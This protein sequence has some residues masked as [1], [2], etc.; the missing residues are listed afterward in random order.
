MLGV[1]RAWRWAA[2]TGD[3]V[4]AQSQGVRPLLQEPT[5]TRPLGQAEGAHTSAR[6]SL[7]ILLLSLGCD[8]PQRCGPPKRAQER[9]IWGLQ[10]KR[11][12]KAVHLRRCL[13]QGLHSWGGV[14]LPDPG[15]PSGADMSTPPG[16][17]PDSRVPRPPGRRRSQPRLALEQRWA[18]QCPRRPASS[19]LLGDVKHHDH[20]VAVLVHIQELRV[21]GHLGLRLQTGNQT[22]ETGH[23][24][25]ATSWRGLNVSFKLKRHPLFL[26]SGEKKST[27]G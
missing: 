22:S 18:S 15:L 8:E 1:G 2:P 7:L 11:Q 12:L 16:P 3:A 23:D 27:Q 21:Q 17:L 13:Q 6:P 25:R 24:P 9:G 19:P 20:P 14:C 5:G 26:F 10:H 4:T